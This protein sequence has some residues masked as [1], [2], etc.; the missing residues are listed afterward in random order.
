[1]GKNIQF[2]KSLEEKKQIIYELN[3]Y[4]KSNNDLI[5]KYNGLNYMI[6]VFKT[7]YNPMI[8]KIKT[9]IVNTTICSKCKKKYLILTIR[10]L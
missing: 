1:M 4:R 10:H 6:K 8:F 3:Q 2:A 9:F 5:N 7:K